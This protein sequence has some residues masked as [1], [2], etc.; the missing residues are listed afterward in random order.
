M[1]SSASAPEI[2]IPASHVTVKVGIIDT[3]ARLRLPTSTFL[4]PEIGGQTH[5]HGPAYSFLIEHPTH[6]K[7]LFDLSLRKDWENLSPAIVNA[8]KAGGWGL[9]VERDV[10]DVLQSGGI[11]PADIKSVIWRYLYQLRHPQVNPR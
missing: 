7:V 3:G 5:I 9:D 8:A 11:D 2:E 6:G 10:V 4:E 1:A